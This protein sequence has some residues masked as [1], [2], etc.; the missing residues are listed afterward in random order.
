VRA[1][2]NAI[3]WVTF[4]GLLLG[5]LYW[6]LK[7][8][9]DGHHVGGQQFLTYQLSISSPS[10][11]N[12]LPVFKVTQGDTVSLRIRSDRSGE[13]HVHG[14]ERKVVLNPDG[15]VALTFLANNTGV[16]PVHLHDPDGSMHSLGTL[17][18]QPK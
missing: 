5:G 12:E 18:V 16:F 10:P 14:Y 7:T 1:S 3:V 13:V 8:S 2:S 15:E 17:D 4:T 6:G 9:M 11:G